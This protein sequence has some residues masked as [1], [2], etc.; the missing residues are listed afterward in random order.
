MKIIPAI[1]IMNGKCVRLTK[2]DYATGKIYYDDPLEVA[3]LFED[4]GIRYLH[5]V[6]LDGAKAKQIINA[7]TLERIAKNTSLQI[8][9][10]G[11][12]KSA[13]DL[14][15]AF[16]AGAQQVTVGSVAVQNPDLMLAWVERYGP[17]KI[18]LGADCRSRKIAVNGWLENSAWDVVDFIL[19]YEKKGIL[20]T[21]VSDIDKDGM[22][23][24][25][26]FE[27]Y[28]EIISRATMHLVASGGISSVED[29]IRLKETGCAGAIVGKALYEGNIDLKDVR[30]LC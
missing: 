21:I 24:G 6:D 8:D 16:D 5:L 29:L 17:E 22:L 23:S 28:E 11:G 4:S 10:G 14:R 15:I 18:I 25:P 30:N 9:F 12:I 1:D 26:S 19:E 7:P 27:L 20:H 2:G 13:D 3:Q